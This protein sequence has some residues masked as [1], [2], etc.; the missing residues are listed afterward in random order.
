M[1]SRFRVPPRPPSGSNPVHHERLQVPGEKNALLVVDTGNLFF[2]ADRVASSGRIMVDVY[3]LLGYDAVNLSWRD[4]GGGKEQALKILKAARFRIVSANLLDAADDR[5]LA[6][7][8]VV[9]AVGPTK[10]AVVGITEP[11]AGMEA[12]AVRWWPSRISSGLRRA[13]AMVLVLSPSS[14]RISS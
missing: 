11:P 7:P 6:A 10:V 3:D 9:K 8:I 13:L 12:G 1:P 5:L 14:V 4:F 2:G